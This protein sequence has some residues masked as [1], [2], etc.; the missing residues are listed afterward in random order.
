MYIPFENLPEESKIWIY[1]SNRKFSDEEIAEMIVTRKIF[2][3]CKII[4]ELS[5]AI[6]VVVIRNNRMR[7]NIYDILSLK[8]TSGTSVFLY[9]NILLNEMNRI[10]NNKLE[11]SK[12]YELIIF[13]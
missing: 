8:S 1:Q 7:K 6:I 9:Y 12:I 3:D 13:S 10:K 4:Y 5:I 11:I 2:R